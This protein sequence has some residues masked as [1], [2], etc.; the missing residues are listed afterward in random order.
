VG[1]SWRGGWLVRW[2]SHRS[3][4]AVSASHNMSESIA[5][6]MSLGGRCAPRTL[7]WVAHLPAPPRVLRFFAIEGRTTSCNFAS[8][9]ERSSKLHFAIV[10][11]KCERVRMRSPFTGTRTASL[12]ERRV[13]HGNGG[14]HTE[15]RRRRSTSSRF[16]VPLPET[17]IGVLARSCRNRFHWYLP[18][19]SPGRRRQFGGQDR[20]RFRLSRVQS[21]STYGYHSPRH[22]P[23]IR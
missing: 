3:C 6:L 14:S 2:G 19:L 21:I 5:R 20:W 15:E 23:W 8:G 16:S 9:G 1:G 10:W 22:H 12:R 7:C 18:R 4:P 13:G 11:A 17:P